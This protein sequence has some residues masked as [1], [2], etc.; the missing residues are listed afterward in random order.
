MALTVNTNI[1][2]LGVQKNLNRASDALG[3][4]MSRLSSGLKINSAKD[5]AAG[6]QIANRLTSQVKGL[7]VAVK[8]ANDGISIAQTAEGAMQASTD[9]L[10]RMREL[11]L[12]SANGSNSDEDRSSLQQ[13]FTALSGELTRIANTT[14]FGGRNLLDGT[15]TST[16]FQV[17]ANANETISFGMRSISASDLKGNYTEASVSGAA[18][19]LSAV[20]T[21][22][23][24]VIT[25]AA[26]L[27][28]AASF[29]VGDK[30]IGAAGDITLG[31]NTV[32]VVADDTL[33]SVVKKI[34]DASAAGAAADKVTASVVG[35][36]LNI[37]AATGGTVAVAGT[38]APGVAVL[39][40]LGVTA[41]PAKDGTA[42]NPAL[43]GIA[44]LKAQ[45]VGAAGAGDL[46]IGSSVV[47]V[48]ATDTLDQVVSK[49]NAESANT[50]VTAKIEKS[51]DGTDG[52]LTLS[53]KT[54]FTVGRASTQG[55]ADALFGAG[56]F[57]AG[58]DSV[59]KT[60]SG[61]TSSASIKVNGAQVDIS[62]SSTM[63]DIV[64][65]INTASTTAKNGVTASA[66]SDGRLILTSADGKDVK[67]ENAT[68][69]ALD[70]LG[71]TSGTTKAKLVADTSISV[72]GVE[73]KFSKGSD[74]SDIAEAI[75]SSSTG[76]TASVNAET[77]T[78]EFRADEDITIA[79][80]SNG[81]GLAALGLAASTTKA[82]TQETSVS[83]LSI[84]D[85]AS[86]QQAIQALDGAMQQVDSQ[87]AS[88][89]AVQNRF[90]STVSNLNS[91]SENS[92]AARSRVQDAD[93]AA[94]TAE[95]TKQQ[96]LQ[97]ASTAI[98]SQA[99]Q[100]PSSV[101]KLLG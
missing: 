42:G 48:A 32:S 54:D 15:F 9:I 49:I 18:S 1:T 69:G 98:L 87:R 40:A 6:L 50:G 57:T 30:K 46:V 97:Q 44:Q 94:E 39:A 33:D 78:L 23:A 31:A 43:A 25:S 28:G 59:Q 101:L 38:G 85:S 72:N 74:M 51:A 26:S 83:S 80:G 93:F 63:D 41:G 88:L 68:A 73:V 92:T 76:V 90:D 79:D 75:N 89:G 86:A 91:I 82:V 81:T 19:K 20:V 100:L 22:K 17:G 8:N 60:A 53:S 84:L 27:S 66:S 56:K 62:A 95:L 2:S 24:D 55:T 10:Q 58:T 45:P 61:L 52:T 4:S 21:G 37:Q 34:N 71:L 67:L 3:T 70:S 36:K 96:T 77:G 65:A 99:N 14:T 5:D 13:E 29:V 47:T 64:A 12:Q 16:S 7:T 11:A 35:G